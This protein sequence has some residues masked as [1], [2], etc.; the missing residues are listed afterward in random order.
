[1]SGTVVVGPWAGSAAA[2]SVSVTRRRRAGPI[3]HRY[4]DRYGARY[5][6]DCRGCRVPFR[7]DVE[8]PRDRLCRDCREQRP[9]LAPPALFEVREADR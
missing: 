2:P 6:I 8:V 7:P 9:D 3:P 4:R 5:L 1:M